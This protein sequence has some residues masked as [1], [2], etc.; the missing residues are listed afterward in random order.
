MKECRTAEEAEAVIYQ[1][2]I[3][4]AC[5]ILGLDESEKTVI[6]FMYLFGVDSLIALE[7]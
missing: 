2:L 4:K 7:I 5:K 6:D 1:A 3:D